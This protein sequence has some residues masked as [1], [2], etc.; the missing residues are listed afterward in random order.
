MIEP[1][2][3]TRPQPPGYPAL[4]QPR[5]L[6]LVNLGESLNIRVGATATALVEK[7]TQLDQTL[8]QRLITLQQGSASGRQLSSALQAGLPLQL[9]QL[10]INGQPL[11]ALTSQSL[12][13]GQQL[14]VQL[15]TAAQLVLLPPPETRAGTRALL[16]DSYRDVLPRQQP[17]QHLLQ[18][19]QNL[20]NLPPAQQQSLLPAPVRQS[21][22]AISQHIHTPAQLADP[23]QLQLALAN[24]GVQLEARLQQLPGSGAQP[25]LAPL[26]L[27]AALLQLAQRLPAPGSAPALPLTTLLHLLKHLSGPAAAD[28]KLSQ[29]QL[30]QS[31]QQQLQGAIAKLQAQQLHSLSQQLSQPDQPLSQHWSIELPVRLGE[32]IQPLQVRIDEDWIER[33]PDKENDS[34][35]P[36]APVKER[37]WTVM[38]SLELPEHGK[39]HAQLKIIRDSVS[40]SLWAEQLQTLQTARAHLDLLRQRLTGAGVNVVA[41]DCYPGAPPQQEMRLGYSLVNTKA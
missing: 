17:L 13:V 12:Q 41:L 28:A 34:T 6:N 40:A 32:Q 20:R 29:D 30:L 37:L 15:Q 36:T 16:A 11:L 25:N 10:S 39:F 23:K 18:L 26:D 22:A 3:N 38:L 21:L 7:V 4:S 19:V 2:A 24:S 35:E 27:K 14:Q 8:Q 1:P 9:T 31:L 33:E 5:S